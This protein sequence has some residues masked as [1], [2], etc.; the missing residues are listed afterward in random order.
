M[1]RCRRSA[2]PATAWGCTAWMFTAC[3]PQVGCNLR[4]AGQRAVGV[5]NT[6]P[7]CGCDGRCAPPPCLHCPTPAAGTAPAPS[8]PRAAEHVVQFLQQVDP[9]AAKRAK[10]RYACFDRCAPWGRGAAPAVPPRRSW[11]PCSLAPRGPRCSLAATP[12]LQLRRRLPGVWVRSGHGRR[13]IVCRRR[14]GHA[15][16][17]S[18]QSCRVRVSPGWGL[19]LGLDTAPPAHSCTPARPPAPA[20]TALLRPLR[21]HLPASST[22]APRARR[23]RLLHSATPRWSRAQKIIIGKVVRVG[24]GGAAT[25][26]P[27]G[28]CLL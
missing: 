7:A 5:C 17:G 10:S 23:W 1:R 24:R 3:T 2:A 6:Q 9:D 12:P 4:Q 18:A 21:S 15:E 16:G 11:P 25:E 19:P 28:P 20:R 27:L 26:R 8:R 14:G 13:P 22:T